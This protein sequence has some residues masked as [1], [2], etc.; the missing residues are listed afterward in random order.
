MFR[1]WLPTN[2]A[3]VVLEVTRR[4]LNNWHQRGLIEK[5]QQETKGRGKQTLWL[6]TVPERQNLAALQGEDC[7]N[8]Y[9]QGN[10]CGDDYS[11]PCKEGE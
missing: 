3:T 1:K 6:V 11:C 8:C 7:Q 9:G 5:K 4:T 10:G 2:R